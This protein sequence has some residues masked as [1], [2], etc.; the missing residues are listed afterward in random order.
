[1][2]DAQQ[3]GAELQ[4]EAAHVHGVAEHQGQQEHLTGH[5]RSRHALEHFQDPHHPAQAVTVGHGIVAFG[6][7]DIAALA[8][9]L[10]EAR[11]CPQGS[12]EA[13]WFEAVDELRSR[14]FGH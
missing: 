3:K 9:A 13:D 4:G 11:G 14:G 2:Y 1:M 5:E 12:P 8:H 7:S 10:W 6:H